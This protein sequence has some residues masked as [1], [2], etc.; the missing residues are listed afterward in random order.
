MTCSLCRTPPSPSPLCG[1]A[2]CGLWPCEGGLGQRCDEDGL[3]DSGVS[4]P[5]P[6]PFSAHTPAPI[7]RPSMPSH[8]LT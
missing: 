3:W 6:E 5:T 7:S 2:G 8:A 1:G 4:A